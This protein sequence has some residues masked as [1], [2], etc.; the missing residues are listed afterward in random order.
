MFVSRYM[1]LS[2]DSNG[3]RYY[4]KYENKYEITNYDGEFLVSSFWYDIRKFWNGNYHYVEK[5][6]IWHLKWNI[7]T[8]LIFITFG[9]NGIL[10]YFSLLLLWKSG[11]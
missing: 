4:G 2:F 6:S 8:R 3:Y 10:L 7:F 5:N 1:S 11:T 9:Y